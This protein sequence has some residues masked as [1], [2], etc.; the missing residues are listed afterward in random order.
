MEIVNSYNG[1]LTQ[2]DDVVIRKV[3]EYV[4]VI[5]SDKIQHY[6]YS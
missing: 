4:K 5:S 2:F 3:V 6:L 1:T